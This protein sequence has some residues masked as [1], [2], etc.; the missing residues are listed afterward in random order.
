[1]R[2]AAAKLTGQ[3]RYRRIVG[4]DPAARTGWAVVDAQGRR[5]M[6]AVQAGTLK[7]Q[8]A[9][10][11]QSLVRHLT[12]PHVRPDLVAIED[13]YYGRNVATLKS[14][15]ETRTRFLQEFQ[16]AGIPAILVAAN[17]WQMGL[18]KGMIGPRS[19]RKERK[20]AAKKYGQILF[21]EHAAANQ[22]EWDACLIAVYAIRAAL[23]GAPQ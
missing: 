9:A 1:M 14:L 19:M 16:A 17:D 12:Q 5:P 15:V 7:G 21:G 20:A 22:D 3:A 13:Q 23:W 18:L 11:V 6:R 10:A 4:I 8:D 2:E